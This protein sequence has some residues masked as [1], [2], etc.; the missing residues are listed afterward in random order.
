[1]SADSVVLQGRV[2]LEAMM[3][4]SCVIQRQSGT[5]TDPATG[6][7]TPT[8]TGIYTGKC[9]LR[10]PDARSN[11]VQAAGQ[12]VEVQSPTLSIP[13]TAAG[14]GSVRPGDIATVTSPLDPNIVTVRIAGIHTQTH[15]TARRFPV[16]I[17]S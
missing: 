2:L 14:S 8:F 12:T 4:S 5:T 17:Q 13:V 15:S 11:D 9:R 16:E 1:M 3:T 7:D 6:I 10:M